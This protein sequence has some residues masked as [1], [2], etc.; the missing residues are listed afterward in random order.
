MKYLQFLLEVHSTARQTCISSP[1]ITRKP[2]RHRQVAVCPRTAKQS[3]AQNRENHPFCRG[4]Q[5]PRAPSRPR[6]LPVPPRSGPLAPQPPIGHG[7]RLLEMCLPT[8]TLRNGH[9]PCP[10]PA[11]W[12]NAFVSGSPTCRALSEIIWPSWAMLFAPPPFSSCSPA[13]APVVFPHAS[14]S[15]RCFAFAFRGGNRGMLGFQRRSHGRTACP[16]AAPGPASLGPLQR[17]LLSQ[18]PA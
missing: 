17:A 3:Q 4:T 14:H 11:I 10:K 16:A 15:P 1:F 12:S 6:T 7:K 18:S 13:L 2:A 5:A 8:V 9:S